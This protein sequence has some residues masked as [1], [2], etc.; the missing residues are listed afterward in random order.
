VLI[1]LALVGS[2]GWFIWNGTAQHASYPLPY[3]LIA[4]FYYYTVTMPLKALWTHQLTPYPRFN[5]LLFV[6]GVIGSIFSLFWLAY[7]YTMLAVDTRQRLKPVGR[8]LSAS[9]LVFLVPAAIAVA[10]AVLLGIWYGGSFAWRWMFT[11][12]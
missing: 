5:V 12:A 2:L 1:V 6:V 10:W 7:R 3:N 4:E 9:V 11:A 8:V